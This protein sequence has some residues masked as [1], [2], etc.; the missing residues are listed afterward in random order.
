M[1]IIINV[2]LLNVDIPL[3][4]E[5]FVNILYICTFCSLY[6]YVRQNKIKTNTYIKKLVFKVFNTII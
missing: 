1:D 2:F 5:G 6:I 4:L 3:N